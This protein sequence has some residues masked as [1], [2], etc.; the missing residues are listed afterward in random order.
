MTSGLVGSSDRRVVWPSP[1]SVSLLATV[2]LSTTM[3]IVCAPCARR[4]ST[5][6]PTASRCAIARA[7]ESALAPAATCTTW[8]GGGGDGGKDGG[9]IGG[10][11]GGGGGTFNRLP[12]S[13]T[14]SICEPGE[15]T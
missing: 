2:R 13:W 11:G 4:I 5:G 7:S 9:L 15:L 1:I 6:S 8:R 3:L 10:G 14:E 12:Q